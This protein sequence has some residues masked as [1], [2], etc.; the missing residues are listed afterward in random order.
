MP[1]EEEFSKMSR[2][3]ELLS[4]IVH[5]DSQMNNMDTVEFSVAKM[6]DLE[7]DWEEAIEEA[8]ELVLKKGGRLSTLTRTTNTSLHRRFKP[9][10]NIVENDCF[11]VVDEYSEALIWIG[12]VDSPDHHSIPHTERAMGYWTKI[13]R[14]PVLKT[15]NRVRFEVLQV[16]MKETHRGWFQG[17]VLKERTG[18]VA[19]KFLHKEALSVKEISKLAEVV[20][21]ILNTE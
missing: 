5:L 14:Y 19:I 18:D 3:L 20:L 17:L 7:V 1:Q 21:L 8:R 9:H 13:L 6:R 4:S 12:K 10:G 11:L 2:E 15:K 16:P